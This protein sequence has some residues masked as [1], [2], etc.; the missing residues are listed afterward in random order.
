M[1][2]L[3]KRFETLYGTDAARCMERIAMMVGRYGIGAATRPAPASRWDQ[4]DAMLITYGDTIQAPGEKPLVTLKKFLDARL[5]GTFSFLHVLP[6]FPY[7]SDDGFSVIHFRTVNP[8]MGDWPDIQTLGKDFRLTVDLVLNHVSRQSGWFQ[9]YQ[10]GVAPGRHYFIEVEPGAD[11]SAVVRPRS[12]PLLTAVTT[13]AGKRMVWTTFSDDQIDLNFANP[14]VLFEMLDILL[15]YVSM[16]A[17]IIRLDAIAYLWKRIGTSCIHLPETH[18]IVKL[19]RDFLE[20]V[21]PDVVLLTETNVPQEENYSY[22][23]AGDEAH[24]AYQFALPPL[25]LHALQSGTTKYLTAWATALPVLPPGSTVLNFTASHDGIGVR[26]LQGVL[27]DEEIRT[28]TER[29][30]TLGAQVSTRKNSDGSDSPYELNI[31]YFDA[32]R[33]NGDPDPLHVQRFMCSQIIPMVLKGIPAVYFHSLTATPNDMDGVKRT[34]RARSINRR[35]W[36]Q[37]ELDDA[38]KDK[39]SNAARVFGEYTRLLQLRAGHTAFHPD[40]A[41]RILNLG[42]SVFAVERTS[43]DG[44]EI[45]LAISN[46]TGQPVHVPIDERDRTDLILNKTPEMVGNTVRL[47]PYQSVW[48]T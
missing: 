15:L 46:C 22:F 12:L 33:V 28:L 23:G 6:F 32:M 40:G 5:K 45:I 44:K 21:A 31:T 17:R 38:L 16:G 20:I 24:A 29:V 26:P 7:S 14:D 35:K 27:P 10:A 34:G 2:S 18:E 37:S 9:D 36:T 47:D 25:L 39:S 4:R 1:E 19:F 11:V 48:L 13:P 8:D 3:R 30:K 42:E 43:P 41:Q